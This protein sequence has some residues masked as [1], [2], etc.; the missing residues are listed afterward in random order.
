MGYCLSFFFFEQN[1]IKYFKGHIKSSEKY[2]PG[3]R[4]IILIWYNF[5]CVLRKEHTDIYLYYLIPLET[6]TTKRANK[7]ID[8]IMN[9]KHT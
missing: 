9:I 4:T 1:I 7:W 6:R 2:P 8:M 3:A 5:F